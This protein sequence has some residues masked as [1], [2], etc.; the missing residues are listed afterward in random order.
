MSQITDPEQKPEVSSG[1]LPEL[2]EPPVPSRAPVLQRLPAPPFPRSGFPL[3]GILASVYEHVVQ[4][5]AGRSNGPDDA[6]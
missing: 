1:A 4:V 3:M 2:P 6:S 5:M